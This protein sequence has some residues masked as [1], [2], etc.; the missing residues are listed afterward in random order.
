MLAPSLFFILTTAEYRVQIFISQIAAVNPALNA[1]VAQRFATAHKE[2][3]AADARLLA[4]RVSGG[5]AEPPPLLGVP[6]SVKEAFSVS[7]MPNTAGLAARC[8]LPA[9]EMDAAAVAALR[10]AGAVVLC[11]TNVSELC[12]WMESYWSVPFCFPKARVELC[13]RHSS[14]FY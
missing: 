14:D 2:A 9:A 3:A 10:E 12:M 13:K 7:G 11:V 1:V 6:F 4:W 8:R 5:A